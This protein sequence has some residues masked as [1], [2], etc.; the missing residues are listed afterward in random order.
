MIRLGLR[1]QLGTQF[2]LPFAFALACLLALSF[3]SAPAF[4]Q[5]GGGGNTIGS[6]ATSGVAVDA[7]GVLQTTVVHDPTGDLARHRVEE[8]LARL[9]Q[10]VVRKSPLRKI[11][12]TRLE[13]AIAKRI[14]AGES[15]DDVMRHLAGLTQLQYVF[16]YP[17]SG[18]IV[19]AGP[20]EAWAEAPSGRIMGVE[21][22]R[23]VLE[24]Q[25][26]IIALRAFPRD[27][28]GKK[29]PLIYC[30]IDP[31]EEGLSR[32]HQ[33]MQEMGS[34]FTGPPPAG[35]EQYVVE[36]LRD[37]LG[38]Q[39]ITVGGIPANTHFAQVMVEA[40]YRMKLIGIGL[41]IP[42]V[43]LKSY[44]A[45]AN[46]HEVARNALE[47]WYF[48]PNYECVKVSDD[49][50]AMELVG[51]GVKLVGEAEVVNRDGKRQVSARGNAASQQF[52]NAF[53]KVYPQLAERSPVFAQLRNCIDLAVAAAYIQEQDLYELANWTP[54]VFTDESKYPVETL[55]APTQVATA[56]NSMWKG[57]T[58]VTPIGGGV[59]MRP[60]LALEP[61]NLLDD[62]DQAVA[63]ARTAV[64]LTKL[65]ADQ[66]WWD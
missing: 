49:A 21:T 60:R 61:T 41:E 17:E 51:E 16:C 28:Y 58:L 59:Q 47:R 6:G 5:G 62:E 52:V 31:T 38:T 23:P 57:M 45:R 20:A 33:F 46:P 32:Y 40:D 2:G 36:Q 24:L 15:I 18:D 26:L 29:S 14:E 42:P 34:Q 50:L 12:L 19:L 43:R 30:S 48:V 65:G 35:F 25:D 39:V 8:A 9:D 22:G 27:P 56:V 63:K 55:N 54:S 37:K 10:N 64:D 66:W 1:R 44:V 13:R 53:T 7:Q 11:S 4:A 3:T